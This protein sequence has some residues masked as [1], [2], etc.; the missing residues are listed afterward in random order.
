MKN[1]KIILGIMAAIALFVVLVMVF[2]I[3]VFSYLRKQQREDFITYGGDR[4][5][6][7][8]YVVG[9]RKIVRVATKTSNG[10][11]AKTYEY[12]SETCMEDINTYIMYLVESEEFKV[13]QVGAT[14]DD[15]VYAKESVDDGDVIFVQ[16]EIFDS[17]YTIMTGKGQGEIQP[18]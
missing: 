1:R 5:P 2:V 10:V 6:T 8:H 7:I 18:Y 14:T 9:E 15:V 16:V 4:V 12:R 11:T 3:G 17:G 13:L